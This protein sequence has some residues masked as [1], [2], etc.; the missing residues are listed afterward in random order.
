MRGWNLRIRLARVRRYFRVGPF[1]LAVLFALL[2]N[3]TLFLDSSYTRFL[4]A[5][6]SCA[7]FTSR[8]NDSVPFSLGSET[9]VDLLNDV[10]HIFV[11]SVDGCRLGLPWPL[12][13]K[14]TCVIGRRLDNCAPKEFVT[15]PYIHAMKVSFM[16]AAV[17]RLSS[18]AHYQHVAI[19]EDDI[20]L[21]RVNIS[22]TTTRSLHRII[23][24]NSWSL[25]RFGFRPFFLE[26]S[27]RKRCPSVCRCSTSTEDAGFCHLPRAG[28][29]MRS[30]DFYVVN[31]AVFSVLQNKLTDLRVANSKRIIDTW[32]MRSLANQWLLLPQLSIQGKLDIPEDFQLGLGSLYIHKCAGPRPLPEDITKQILSTRLK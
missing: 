21:R 16:H 3:S 20:E 9:L 30:S 26:E 31:S 5:I 11:L 12:T 23:S 32:A 7:D 6:S 27:S 13:N 14:A 29:D 25:I 28:C 4:S 18:Q 24:S 19:I 1:A 2:Y 15:S 10:E 8:I 17:F 22:Q